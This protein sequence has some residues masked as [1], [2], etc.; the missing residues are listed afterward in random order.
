MHTH[1]KKNIYIAGTHTQ[2]YKSVEKH[3]T[4][5]SS[6]LECFGKKSSLLPVL[7]SCMLFI[8]T[9]T[10]QISSYIPQAHFSK[11]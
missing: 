5:N 2:I 4:P 3:E 1:A 10:G 8:H 9:V 11:K 7:S 6:Q